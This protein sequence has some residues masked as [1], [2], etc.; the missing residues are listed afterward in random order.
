MRSAV[1]SLLRRLEG[2][3]PRL[4]RCLGRHARIATAEAGFGVWDGGFGDVIKRR[5]DIVLFF[6]L[7]SCGWVLSAGAGPSCWTAR[8]WTEGEGPRTHA[9]SG[10][11]RHRRS[12][13]QPRSDACD[14]ALTPATCPS[15]CTGH[16]FSLHGLDAARPVPARL[17]RG[18][19]ERVPEAEGDP[20]TRGAVP[21]HGAGLR[22]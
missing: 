16:T 9:G 21:G 10:A 3:S 7:S 19:G 12:G 4:W 1:P 8:A 5:S 6:F 11:D 15:P 14:P 22:G 18:H 13:F 20:G 2:D 17:P